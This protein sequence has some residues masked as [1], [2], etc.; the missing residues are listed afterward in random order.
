[1]DRDIYLLPL[2]YYDSDAG[3]NNN[4]VILLLHLLHLHI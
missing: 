1:L 3:A 4:G 2:P